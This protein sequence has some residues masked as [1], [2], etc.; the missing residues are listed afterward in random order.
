[1][2]SANICLKRYF[3]LPGYPPPARLTHFLDGSTP[4][5]WWKTELVVVY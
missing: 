2:E 4:S 3:T 5:R 1:V